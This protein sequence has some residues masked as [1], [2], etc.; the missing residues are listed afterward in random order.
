MKFSVIRLG[1]WIL[2]ALAISLGLG[3]HSGSPEQRKWSIK[4]N[5]L[6]ALK[7]ALFADFHFSSPAD[8]ELLATLKRQL[9]YEDPDVV[10]FAGD[11]IG[12]HDIFKTTSRATIVKSLEALAYPKP[13]FAV[14]GNHDNWDSNEAWHEAFDGSTVQLIENRVV[15]TTIN[16]TVLC[17][18]GL[19]D[20]YSNQWDYVSIPKECQ[21][22]TITLTHDPAGLLTPSGDI[23][24]ISFAGHTHCGQIAFPLIG[25]PFVPTRA[26]QDMHCGQF[27]RGSSGIVS[28]GFGTSIIPLRLGPSTK[29]G[30]ELVIIN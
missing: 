12:S 22:H 30:W 3:L 13:A 29:P 27:N 24:T 2:A 19:G 25:A 4:D 9:I 15:K 28:G 1:L 16:E 8:L 6:P 26:P 10:L 20:I 11:Y 21:G 23:E 7:I 17:I 14:L 5:K 18:R